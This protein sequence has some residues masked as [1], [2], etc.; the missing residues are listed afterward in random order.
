MAKHSAMITHQQLDKAEVL[1]AV[2]EGSINS[3]EAINKSNHLTEK[4]V[5]MREDL[6]QAVSVMND[7]ENETR[8]IM[9]KK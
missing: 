7:K 5:A 4:I 6:I 2:A 8:K 9:A 3:T 1:A